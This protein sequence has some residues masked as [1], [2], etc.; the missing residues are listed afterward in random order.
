MRRQLLLFLAFLF[1]LQSVAQDPDLLGY[2]Q[3]TNLVIDGQ[4]N[5]PPSND[6]VGS[7]FVSFMET[8]P[9]N[10]ATG[11]CDALDADVTYHQNNVEFTLENLIQTLGGCALYADDQIYQGLYFNFYK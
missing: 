8:G 6:E 5:I 4:D 10:F 1:S 7:V 11:V 2:W 3:L 9:Y